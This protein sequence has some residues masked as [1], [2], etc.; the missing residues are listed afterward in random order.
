M[1]EKEDKILELYK[2]IKDLKEE[3]D[4]KDKEYKELER[5]YLNLR[6]RY[7]NQNEELIRLKIEL[8]GGT[9]AN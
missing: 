6:C 7:T 8:K 9:N 4:E 5:K 1:F 3:Y 2:T